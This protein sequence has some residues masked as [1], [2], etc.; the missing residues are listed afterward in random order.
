MVINGIIFDLDGTLIDTFNTQLKSW[1][2]AFEKV[3]STLDTDKFIN[4][5]GKSYKDFT[6]SIDPSLTNLDINEVIKTNKKL[7]QERSNEYSLFPESKKILETL[8]EKRITC[9]IASSNPRHVS[10]SLLKQFQIDHLIGK[11]VG[12]DDVKNG[13]PAPDML[14]LALTHH[15]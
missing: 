12:P 1:R 6:F 15:K 10:E 13:K 7:M 11:V 9:M 8:N 2:E 3:G 5:F 14:N 4:N